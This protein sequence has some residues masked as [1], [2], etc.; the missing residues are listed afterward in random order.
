MKWYVESLGYSMDEVMVMGDSLNDYSML[1]MD[2]GACVAMEN[3]ADILKETAS[4]RA[5][6]NEEDGAAI[7]IEKLLEGRLEELRVRK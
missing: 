4:Y 6:S 3:A 5:P 2:F 7:A 1:S